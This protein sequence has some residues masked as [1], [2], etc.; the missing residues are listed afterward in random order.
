MFR[1]SLF[2]LACCLLAPSA[3]AQATALTMGAGFI[4]PVKSSMSEQDLGGLGY[5]HTS[6]KSGSE[7]GDVMVHTVHVDAASTVTIVFD[8]GGAQELMRTQSKGFATAE[9]A[10]IGDTLAQLQMLYPEGF[11]TKAVAEGPHLTF[12]PFGWHDGGSRAVFILNTDGL[13]AGC[14]LDE[15][16]CP[17]FSDRRSEAF[18]TWDWPPLANQEKGET[19]RPSPR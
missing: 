5:P 4:G 18:E 1:Q 13:T 3:T 9:G 16:V 19:L 6:A 11:V 10:R 7:G 17:D 15:E 12:L 2:A 14:L 8:R